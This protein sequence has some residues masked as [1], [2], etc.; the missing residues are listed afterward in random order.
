MRPENIDL[1]L[2]VWFVLTGASVAFIAWD[3]FTRTP[4]MKVMKW[5]WLLVALYTGPVALAVYWF[6]CREPGPGTHETFV[7]P[8]WKQ[9]VGS[10][11]HCL[12]G[13]ATGVIV[14]AVAVAGAGL[15]MVVDAAVEYIVGLAVGLFIFQALF[16]REIL[17]VN[18]DTAVRATVYPEWLSMNCVMA[19]MVPAMA[20]VMSRDMRAMQPASIRFWGAMSFATLVGA[21]TGLPINM[22]LV[23]KDLK[24]GMGTDRVL[25]RGGTTIPAPPSHSAMS[26]SL[27]TADRQST[28]PLPVRAE[29]PAMSGMHAAAG[30]SGW[31]RV[32]VGIV[33][34]VMLAAGIAIAIRY[35]GLLRRHPAVMHMS[36]AAHELGHNVNANGHPSSSLD[37]RARKMEHILLTIASRRS[38][39][40]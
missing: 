27:S 8:L 24:H 32:A 34:I 37:R 39:P 19:G 18:Y 10:T 26:P 30:V 31:Q 7:A 40:R 29:V 25:G 5:G 9:T 14:S 33:S 13:D 3:L 2:T 38:E 21:L 1:A 35:G 6:S 4:E 15:P 12:A 36:M 20:L 28:M 16:M 22:W 17:G 23:K 11:I